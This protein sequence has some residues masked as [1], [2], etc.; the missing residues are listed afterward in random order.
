ML[1]PTAKIEPSMDEKSTNSKP[2]EISENYESLT[3]LNTYEQNSLSAYASAE[4]SPSQTKSMIYKPDIKLD[5]PMFP[6]V[7]PSCPINSYWGL[8]AATSLL[9]DEEDKIDALNASKEKI[10]SQSKSFPNNSKDSEKINNFKEFQSLPSDQCKKLNDTLENKDLANNSGQL[11]KELSESDLFKLN[12]VEG[13]ED[14]VNVDLKENA[15]SK[16]DQ[17][18][19]MSIPKSKSSTLSFIEKIFTSSKTATN[20][21]EAEPLKDIKKESTKELSEVHAKHSL[22]TA[23]STAAISASSPN[24]EC[25]PYKFLINESKSTDQKE[26]KTLKLEEDKNNISEKTNIVVDKLIENLASLNHK[27]SEKHDPILSGASSSK[28]ITSNSN[29]KIPQKSKIEKSQTK[30]MKISATAGRAPS[31]SVSSLPMS[32]EA[33]SQK[34]DHHVP[35]SSREFCMDLNFNLASAAAATASGPIVVVD[36]SKSP[37][38]Q[39]HNKFTSNASTSSIHNDLKM[40]LEESKDDKKVSTKEKSKNDKPNKSTDVHKKEKPKPQRIKNENKNNSKSNMSTTSLNSSTNEQTNEN[41]PLSPTSKSNNLNLIKMM[42]LMVDNDGTKTGNKKNATKQHQNNMKE[43]SLIN[44]AK[45]NGRYKYNREFLLQIRE[46]RSNFIDQI[47][48]D[49][50]KAYCYCMN[51][52][53]WD[54]E[55]YFD[56]VSFPGEFDRIT[57]NRLNYNRSAS[58]NKANH[59]RKKNTPNST[60]NNSQYSA[61]SIHQFG[62]TPTTVPRVSD[63]SPQPLQVPKNSPKIDLESMVGNKNYEKNDKKSKNQIIRFDSDHHHKLDAD[64]ILLDL[65]KKN[66]SDQSLNLI[67]MLNKKTPKV[68]NSQTHNILDNLFKTSSKSEKKTSTEPT[69]HKHYPLILTAQELEMSQLNEDKLSKCKL[70]NEISMTKLEQFQQNM[71]SND[72]FAYKQ[73]VKNLNNHPLNSPASINSKLEASLSKLQDKQKLTSKPSWQV[74]NDGTNVLKEL[75]NLKTNVIKTE[76]PKTKSTKKT[77]TKSN[78]SPHLSMSHGS[79]SG[80]SSI[81]SSPEEISNKFPAVNP[82]EKPFESFM[83]EENRKHIEQVLNQVL[84]KSPNGLKKQLSSNSRS[85]IEDLI[86]KI[87]IQKKKQDLKNTQDEHFNTL[88]N[89][90]NKQKNQLKQEKNSNIMKWFSDAKNTI[91]NKSNQLSAQ[92]LSEIEF[93]E[94]HRPINNINKLN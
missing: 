48:P 90:M 47:Y 81:S 57:S 6:K 8:P 26:V 7:D 80:L 23:L 76:K 60:F 55:K 31:K 22:T 71:E 33:G 87:N 93:M 77:H 78:R 24:P 10:M 86:E 18:P 11:K 82:H 39:E 21:T 15:D 32:N 74:S 19:E 36:N 27:E 94:M 84:N 12:V 43:P 70:P 4:S 5:E 63:D 75:L 58:Y 28:N 51:G 40:I 9:I 59:Q 20:A 2:I 79:T 14:L 13:E 49:I 66:K 46:Q 62:T 73:L 85:P 61:K 89:K 54:P 38:T 91:P 69:S 30:S 64:K 83:V 67:D 16:S 35:A 56:I 1:E 92:S 45:Q 65:I 42:M 88:L 25:S 72:S 3:S 52:K 29:L 34:V 44:L 17:L 53:Y 50:F 68:N 41:F 37:V